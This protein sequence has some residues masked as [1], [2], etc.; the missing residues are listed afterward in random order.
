MARRRRPIGR[1]NSLRADIDRWRQ[2]GEVAAIALR[3]L[4]WAVALA[5]ALA[6][7]DWCGL[8]WPSGE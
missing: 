4:T 7:G 2:V 6:S 3:I 1:N 8:T 5:G